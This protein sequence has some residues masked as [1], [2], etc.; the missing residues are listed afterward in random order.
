MNLGSNAQVERKIVFENTSTYTKYSYNLGSIT[1]GLYTVGGTLGD[2]LDKTKAWFDNTIDISNIPKGNYAVYITNKANISDYGELNEILGRDL[3]NV[4]LTI[5]N[6]NY[7]FSINKD[8]RY[9][10]E[11][12]VK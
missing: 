8:N 9:R 7:T 4:K 2:K 3:S 5:N 6:K 11:L 12:N 10:I 1:N